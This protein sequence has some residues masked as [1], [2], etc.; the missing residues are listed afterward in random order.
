MRNNSFKQYHDWMKKVDKNVNLRKHFENQIPEALLVF[1]CKW[2]FKLQNDQP[3]ETKRL[4][5]CLISLAY[6]LMYGR[7]ILDLLDVEDILSSSCKITELQK[8]RL[9]ISQ[10][11]AFKQLK[12]V[13]V[14]KSQTDVWQKLIQP[15]LIQP[16]RDAAKLIQLTMPQIQEA[17]VV[18][19][20]SLTQT[21]NKLQEF[22]LLTTVPNLAARLLENSRVY[23]GFVESTIQ[24]IEHT[25]NQKI[26][27]A[28]QISLRQAEIQLL[29]TTETLSSIISALIDDEVSDTRP[30][31]LPII[32]QYELITAIESEDIEDEAALIERSPA[33]KVF[34]VSTNVLCLV[35][36]CNEVV[37]SQV[38]SE[39]FK[40]TNKLLE[41][42]ADFPWLLPETKQRFAD[43]VDCLYFIFYEG[44][45]KD[46]LRFLKEHGGVLERTDC[47]LIWCIKHLR[48]KWLRHDADHGKEPDIRKS[49]KELSA[50]FSWLGLQH[51][52]I[53]REHFRYL[54]CRLLKEAEAFLEKILE[55]LIKSE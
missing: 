4:E 9:P 20:R 39:I 22:K 15:N 5:L 26:A 17:A 55:K 28:L 51:A 43:F 14:F 30:L 53:S 52:P 13:E 34:V 29:T 37:K 44:A 50:K 11:A 6:H 33:A 40:P 21:I 10:L 36:K 27:R 46:N 8:I 38:K 18:W 24:R 7:T 1:W 41:V 32:Q 16:N 42:F 54:H 47:E 25:E 35:T 19:H 23:T 12:I 49:W 3:V 2:Y 31:D 48:N 45:G